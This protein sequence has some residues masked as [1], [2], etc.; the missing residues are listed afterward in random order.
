MSCN[1]IILSVR[2]EKLLLV[3]TPYSM[4]QLLERQGGFQKHPKLLL[5]RIGHGMHEYSL[6][7]PQ[8]TFLHTN[9]R[10]HRDCIYIYIYEIADK[11]PTSINPL[12]AI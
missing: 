10:V 8:S 6:L 4:L 12:K 7:S 5:L 11:I 9:T 1:N 2:Y 3:V